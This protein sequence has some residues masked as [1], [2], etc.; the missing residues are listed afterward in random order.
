MRRLLA[1]LALFPLPLGATTPTL[2]SGRVV[3]VDGRELRVILDAAV[4]PSPGDPVL[5]HFELP[6]GRRVSVGR[7]EVARVEGAVVVALQVEATGT[8][9]VGQTAIVSSLRPKNRPTAAAGAWVATATGTARLRHE[10]REIDARW[11]REVRDGHT[12]DTYYVPAPPVDGIA[13]EQDG[14]PLWNR[15]VRDPAGES[16]DRA[17]ATWWFSRWE[18]ADGR[19]RQRDTRDL[20]V[21]VLSRTPAVQP[22]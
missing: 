22:Q 4:D 15:F 21:E 12:V 9:A 7:W 16:T 5:V 3:A 13:A 18:R 2:L 10:G 6:G 17:G 20:A 19:W 11:Q 14:Q 1:L 8:P